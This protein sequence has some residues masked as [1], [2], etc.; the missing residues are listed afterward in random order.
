MMALVRYAAVLFM[1]FLAGCG[2]GPPA[3]K[4]PE[5]A[6]APPVE[7]AEAV[8]KESTVA[9]GP[10]TAHI[11]VVDLNGAPLAEMAPI[12][13]RQ[14]NAFDKPLATGALT[15]AEGRG[16]IQFDV[17][18]KV[19]VR[20]WDPKLAYFPNNFYE[21]LPRSGDIEEELQVVMVPGA[22]LTAQFFDPSGA[23]VAEE[24]VAL[25]LDHP[26]RGPWWPAEGETAADGS[27]TFDSI[28]AGEFQLRFQTRSGL[29]LE[30]P[31]TPLPPGVTTDIGVVTLQ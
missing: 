18:G 15:D 2:G 4:A 12:V 23:I 6:S 28:P 11:R 7:T 14:P 29:R 25:M 24:P 10:I 22:R 3:E 31:V 19:C 26:A 27:V 30:Y 21:V 16:L 9:E 20:A 8:E 13:T 17:H 5:A 1:G